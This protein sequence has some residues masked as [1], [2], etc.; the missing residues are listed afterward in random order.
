MEDLRC[1]FSR[2]ESACLGKGNLLDELDHELQ[3]VA[4]LLDEISGQVARL[5]EI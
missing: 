5:E 3:A 2:C 4:R 1:G